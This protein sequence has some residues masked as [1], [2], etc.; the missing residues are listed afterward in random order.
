VVRALSLPS[1]NS[2]S[3]VKTDSPIPTNVPQVQ[4]EIEY[5]CPP[6]HI[7]YTPPTWMA[8]RLS[9]PSINAS[10][11]TRNVLSSKVTKC[12][13]ST[14]L[15]NSPFKTRMFMPGE[16]ARP[17]EGNLIRETRSEKPDQ[18]HGAQPN[19]TTSCSCS[20]PRKY[21]EN[22]MSKHHA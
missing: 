19:Q 3:I 18:K 8:Y 5:H 1:T 22:T 11:A 10:I 13:D 6:G 9:S 14:Q 20:Q 21:K 17:S 15:H 7:P 2:L 12:T 4:F 16:V